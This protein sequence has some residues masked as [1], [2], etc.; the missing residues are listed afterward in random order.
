MRDAAACRVSGTWSTSPTSMTWDTKSDG[1]PQSGNV[2]VGWDE[3]VNAQVV[4]GESAR[5]VYEA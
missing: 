1:F 2:S 4:L 5:E 3:S